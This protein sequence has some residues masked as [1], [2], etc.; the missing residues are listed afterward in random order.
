MPYLAQAIARLN[1][2]T[3]PSGRF[4]AAELREQ[5]RDAS[6]A[7]EAAAALGLADVVPEQYRDALV[8]YLTELPPSVDAA[9][10]AAV[11]SALDRN[12]R[13]MLS[14]QPGYA[15]DVRVWED[16]EGEQGMVN[17]HLTGPRP[18]EGDRAG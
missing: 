10:V 2:Q 15:H 3:S 17:V 13:V 12:V 7:L 16:V 5:L 4:D 18:G 1:E 14:W 8:R 9:I 11:R 6:T